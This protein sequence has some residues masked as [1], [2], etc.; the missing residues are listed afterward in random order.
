MYISFLM[1]KKG[2]TQIIKKELITILRSKTKLTIKT[3]W[4]YANSGEHFLNWLLE[5]YYSQLIESQESL[6]K[7]KLQEDNFIVNESGDNWISIQN[8]VNEWLCEQSKDISKDKG[9]FKRFFKNI[10]QQGLN[11]DN[12]FEIFNNFKGYDYLFNPNRG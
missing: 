7:R 1:K 4:S 10:S 3:I 8:L 9:C 12:F 6:K 5:K 11:P 2:S